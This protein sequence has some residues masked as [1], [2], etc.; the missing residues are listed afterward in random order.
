MSTER[1][2][3][4]ALLDANDLSPHDR[5][6]GIATLSHLR[7]AEV[8]DP[9]SLAFHQCFT[10][11]EGFFGPRGEMEDR[12]ALMRFVAERVIDYGGGLE[13]TYHLIGAWAGDELVGV[14]DCYVDLDRQNGFSIVALSHAYVAPAWRRSGLGA[15]LRALPVTLSRRVQTERLGTTV[16]TL[17][18]AE[19][20]PVD[21]DNPDTIIRLIAYG[22]S[23]FSVLDPQRFRYSQPD[24][25]CSPGA[26]H[27][28]IALLGVVRPLGLP[29]GPLPVELCAAYPTLFH[30]CHRMYL[31]A[32]QV[33]PSSSHAFDT[34]AAWT[35]PVRLLP[36]PTGRG[37]L[38][39][40]APLVRGAVLPLYPRGLWGENAEFGLAEEEF[41]RVVEWGASG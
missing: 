20:E 13:G 34:L 39:G 31:P 4:N 26:A 37:D 15:I 8:Y 25:R 17:V 36:L 40:L 9:H 21:P 29:E 7:L 6:K 16:P 41:L 27:T 3:T 14:R 24:F 32:S 2:S 19:M 38:S 35:E 11:L 18:A 10:M 33:D 12:A 5:A 28:G 1:S 30:A 22:R 23:G